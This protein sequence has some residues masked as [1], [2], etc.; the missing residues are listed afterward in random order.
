MKAED[1]IKVEDRLPGRDN[2]HHWTKNVLVH[3][4]GPLEYYEDEPNV[5]IAFYNHCTKQWY[6]LAENSIEVTH[7]MPIEL[8]KDNDNDDTEE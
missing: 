1:W 5:T 7:W 3:C 8:P 4:P 6:D 2:G